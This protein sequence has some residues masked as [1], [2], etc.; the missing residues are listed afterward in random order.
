MSGELAAVIPAAGLGTRM[1]SRRAK[2]LHELNGKSLIR[3]VLESVCPLA[4]DPL[5]VVVGH[6]A[7]DVRRAAAGFDALF[8]VQAEQ[9]GTGDA[10][11][12]A[13][14]LLSDLRADVLVL[15]GDAPALSTG[16][17]AALV[18]F[19]RATG[20]DLSLVTALPEDPQGYG[21]ILRDPAGEVLGVVEERDLVG[22]QK[23]L[24]EVNAGIYCVKGDLLRALVEALRPDN[25][26][27]EYYLTD[28]VGLAIGKGKRVAT[29]AAPDPLEVLGVNSR[30]ELSA[31]ERRLW[32]RVAAKWMERGV[33]I[34][35]PATVYIGDEVTI[36]ADTEIGPNTHL[37][38]RTQIGERCKID[39]TC[40]LQDAHLGNDVHLRFGVVITEARVSDKAVVGPFAHLRPGTELGPEVH[41]GNFVEIKKARIGARTKANHL[42]YLGD[43]T[44]G[45]DTNVGA[46][47]ITCN[48]DGFRKYRTVIG[49]RVQIGSDTQLVAPVEV[50]DD[51]YIGA[52]TTVTKAVSPGALVTSRVPQ[53]EVPGWVAKRRA[54]AKREENS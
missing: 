32:D 50:G 16:T 49:S 22:D 51:A 30:G 54:R 2:V 35:D 29:L 27:R 42:S 31:M 7:D 13:L 48:Y 45:E 3:R 38:G 1:R 10:V 21:R 6:Q 37:R 15:Y 11:A 4:P 18:E 9:R 5:V 53:R 40:Y 19:H 43:A 25:A 44:I 8:A 12:V 33:T 17:L 23:R 52:G 24:R 26:Q 47:T 14:P 20:A 46:G 34:R 39:G 28:I 36:G 41:I